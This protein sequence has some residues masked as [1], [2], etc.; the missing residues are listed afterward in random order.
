[1]QRVLLGIL[2]PSSNTVLEPLTSE[3]LRG[4][5][6]ASA[7][8][9]RFAVTSIALSEGALAQFATPEVVK[10]AELL[11]HAKC[12]VI[13]WSGTSSSWLGFDSDNRLCKSIESSTSAR[14][15]TSVLAFNEILQKTG[16]RRLG[17]VSPYT[18]EVQAAIILNYQ[19]A[20]YE[21]V[22]EQHS[23]LEDNYSFSE[24]SSSQLELM[25]REVATLKPEAILIMCTNLRGA[26]LV[27][28]LE[29]EL[30][31]AIYDS[32]ATVVWKAL[33][34][35]GIDTGRIKGWGRLFREVT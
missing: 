11:E 12:Q 3:M 24:V 19:N 15:C 27:E 33:Q 28:E 34:L 10:A 29:M 21:I 8:F 30:G 32:V 35:S 25:I 23:G 13:G 22:A 5:P 1:M 14:A 4:V 2:T 26:P 7:H 16:A 9:G 18:D 20:G 6:E 17:L 31:I